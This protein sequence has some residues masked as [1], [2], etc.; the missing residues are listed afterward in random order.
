MTDAVAL[1]KDLVALLKEHEIEMAA[2]KATAA[3]LQMSRES[4]DSRGL[5]INAINRELQK[6]SMQR[7]N[8][9]AAILDLPENERIFAQV[10]VEA[11]V[12]KIYE[13]AIT[14]MKKEK[15]AL[16]RPAKP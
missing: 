2:R 14:A 1:V 13:P 5:A 4:Y 7:K 6:L 16:A 10:Q 15:R 12:D 9:R 8:L 3:L 11:V